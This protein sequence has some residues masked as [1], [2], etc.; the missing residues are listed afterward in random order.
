M[1]YALLLFAAGAAATAVGANASSRSFKTNSL[2]ALQPGCTPWNDLKKHSFFL[3]KNDLK[4]HSFFLTK[5]ESEA[6]FLAQCTITN[7]DQRLV[8]APPLC[9][10][11]TLLDITEISPTPCN[12][13]TRCLSFSKENVLKQK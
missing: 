11:K 3:T 9:T 5:V 10:T 6:T 1:K 2:R 12:T 7:T 8:K 13:P 4:K